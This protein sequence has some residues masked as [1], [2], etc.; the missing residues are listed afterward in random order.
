MTDLGKFHRQILDEVIA[1]AANW[2]VSTINA[3]SYKEDSFTRLVTDDL[4]IA[5][6]LESPVVC[7]HEFF[8]GNSAAKINAYGI[9]EEDSRLDV[10]ISDFH[11]N[12][13]VQKISQADIEKRFL[14]AT[15]F[16]DSCLNSGFASLDPSND[17][18][19]MMKTI[20]D[21]SKS[22]DRINII[23][24]TNAL[25]VSRKDVFPVKHLKSIKITHEVWDIERYRRFRSSGASQEPLEVDINHYQ[26]GG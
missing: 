5:G 1:E 14:Q 15:R 23:L 2:D 7:H 21:R 25:S 4:S 3:S 9:P 16:I 19:D 17:A 22:L 11:P 20:Y 26:V 8:K 12:E 18:Y 13:S 6:V 10:V 24:A